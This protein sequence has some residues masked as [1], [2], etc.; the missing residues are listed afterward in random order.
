M[1]PGRGF[2]L[3]CAVFAGTI[4]VGLALPQWAQFV[5]TVALAKGMVVLGLLILMRSGLISFGQGLFYCFGAYTAGALVKAGVAGSVPLLVLAGG[6]AAALLALVTGFLLANYRGIFFGLLS[7][8]LSM[9]LYGVLVKS[10]YLGS[11]DGFNVFKPEQAPSSA[12]LLVIAGLLGLLASLFVQR[13]LRTPLGRLCE[14]IRDN[15]LRVEYMGASVRNA[16]HGKY[17]IAATLA[18]LGGALAAVTVGHIDPDMAYWTTSGEFV[19]IAVLG[20]TASVLA[21][22]FGSIIFAAIYSIAY[23]L[24]PHTWQ[25]SVGTA[26]LLCILFLPEGLWSMFTRRKGA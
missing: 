5:L 19:F 24:S 8:A 11:S 23:D 22:F 7:L 13:Y 26:L 4:G 2:V 10:Q 20:G 15:E 12:T 3:V 16:I 14:A 21:P 9:I 18:G 25:M 17:V 6:A 1:K